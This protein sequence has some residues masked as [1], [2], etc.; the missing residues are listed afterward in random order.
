MTSPIGEFLPVTMTSRLSS[1]HWT[2]PAAPRFLGQLEGQAFAGHPVEQACPLR[3]ADRAVDPE[4]VARLDVRRQD[5]PSA[6]SSNSERGRPRTAASYDAC[7]T[8]VW[9]PSAATRST[10]SPA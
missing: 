10:S 2:E 7:D 5:A 6:S 4:L 3:P 8:S 1:S 9:V